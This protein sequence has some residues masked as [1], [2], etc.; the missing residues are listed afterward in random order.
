MKHT[1]HAVTILTLLIA[2]NTQAAAQDG[3]TLQQ[4]LDYAVENNIQLQ[5][6]AIEQRR[7]EA[8]LKEYQAALWP[9]LTVSTYQSMGYRPFQENATVVQDNKVVSTTHRVTEQGSYGINANWTV[10]NGGINHMNIKN[11]KLQNQQTLLQW[12]Q[13]E[14]TIQEQ[15]AQIYVQ[16]LYCMEAKKVNEQL[17]ATALAQWKRG[18]EMHTC[19]QIARADVAQLEAEYANAQYN[20]VSAQTQIDNYKRQLKTLLQLQLDTP[21]DIVA[22]EPEDERAL[23]PIPSARE[24]Y[25]QALVH[26]PEIASAVISQ[27]QADLALSIARAGHYPTIGLSA[28]IGDSHYSAT[29]LSAG[30]QMK[31][32]L[33]GSIGLNISVP[34]WDQRRTRTNIERAQLEKLNSQ[35]TMD[36]AR[37]TLSSTIEEHWLNASNSQQQF[38]AACTQVQSQQTSYELLNEQFQAGLKNI[39]ELMTGRDR[40]LS[41][42]QSKLQSKYTTL[43]NIQLLRFYQGEPLSL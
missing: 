4:C 36:D 19:G 18:Q 16:I 24:V 23:T 2:G 20:V 33:N 8:S 31:E 3:W 25:E 1:L 17:E 37:T 6:N 10:W 27:Q 13:T 29:H 30:A 14:N 21:F 38:I 28:S 26:R 34:I 9:S 5:K 40:V 11:Q 7:G 39:V 43:L 35:L 12:K 42:Q 22:K 32:N 15:I 41:A